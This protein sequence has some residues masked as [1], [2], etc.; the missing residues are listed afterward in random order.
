MGIFT[1]VIRCYL[2]EVASYA[3]G[4]MLDVGCGNKPYKDLFANVTS[5]IGMDRPSMVDQRRPNTQQRWSSFD[6][7]GSVTEIPFKNES[8]DTILATQ[9]IEHLPEPKQFFAG[10]ARV[11]RP[12]GHLLVTFP[13]VNP[14]HEEPYDFFRFTEY[15]VL[16]FCR[17]AGLEP[18]KVRR[19]GGGWLAAGYIV[20]HLMLASA[21]RANS[22][23]TRVI[24]CWMGH[25]LYWFLFWLDTRSLHSD[26]SVNYVIVAR[27]P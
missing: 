13:L 8:F 20:R 26:V 7:V 10:G 15:G 2:T 21:E 3:C 1:P 22:S 23:L 18:V 5:Y 24:W 25:R 27:K 19:M 12:N 9:L 16:Y 11:L 14:V 17:K 4:R 6:V